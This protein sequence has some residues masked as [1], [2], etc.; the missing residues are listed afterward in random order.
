MRIID[1]FIA[2]N[3]WVIKTKHAIKDA[4]N[5]H[6][7]AIKNAVAADVAYRALVKKREEIKNAAQ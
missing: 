7:E 3:D 4:K 2:A 6:Q 5:T 1:N